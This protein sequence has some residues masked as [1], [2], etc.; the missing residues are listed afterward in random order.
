[1]NHQSIR[2]DIEQLLAEWAWLIDHGRADEAARFYTDDAEQNIAGVTTRGIDAIRDGLRRRRDMTGRTS[3]HVVSNLHL[4]EV[5]QSSISVRWILTLYR[6]DD[7][8]RPP[9]PALIGDVND[10]MQ[11]DAGTWKIR[12][13]QILPI[14][15]A[16]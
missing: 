11:H 5:T 7:S 12:S 10:T 2:A 6:S 4:L 1:M 16:S 8:S 13:R 14:F 15:A 3:R 9:T